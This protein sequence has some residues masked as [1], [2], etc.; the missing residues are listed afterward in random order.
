M[1]YV[2]KM[3]RGVEGNH[4]DGRDRGF[5]PLAPE[6]INRMKTETAMFL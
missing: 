3:G 2:L 4:L 1:S 5:L 6:Q